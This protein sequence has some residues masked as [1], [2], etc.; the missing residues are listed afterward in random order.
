MSDNGNII[1]IKILDRTYNIKCPTEEAHELQ[2][3][4]QLLDERMR[5]FRQSAGS[6]STDR[7]AIVAAL[8]FCHELM[9][10]K[11]QKNSYI[12]GMNQR[13]KDLQDRIQNFL[14]TEEEVAV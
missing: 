6:S 12:D 2:Q 13:I 3:A 8:N 7:V 4:A 1:S 11:K 14:A 10:L 5:E 9:V